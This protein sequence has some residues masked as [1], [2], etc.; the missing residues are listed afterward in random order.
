MSNL[1]TKKP[2]FEYQHLLV[3]DTLALL[4]ADKSNRLQVWRNNEQLGECYIPGATYAE[5][6]RISQQKENS[7]FHSAKAFLEFVGNGSSY[8]IQPKE[9]NRQIPLDNE[10]DRQIIA[11]A[12][13]LARENPHSVIILVTYDRTMKGLS[14]QSGLSNF[15]TLTAKELSDWFFLDYYR[16][17]VPQAVADA[18]QRIKRS[19]PAV[20][21]NNKPANPLPKQQ[22]QP[23]KRKNKQPSQIQPNPEL[24]K[25]RGSSKSQSQHPQNTSNPRKKQFLNPVNIV[26]ASA[27]AA[28]IVLAAITN[29]TT[30][31]SAA[32]V[33]QEVIDSKPVKPTPANL[34]T[35]AESSIIQFQN[36]KEPSILRQSLNEL[37]T[38]KNQQALR[39][40]KE[41]EQ[42]LSR[43]KHKYAIEVLASSGQKA[44]AVKMLEEIPQSYSEY[45]NV[46]KSLVK[47]QRMSGK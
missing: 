28:V 21:Q 22:N 2:V 19:Q 30:N 12:H 44:E 4:S 10:K 33:A 3:F 24:P 7:D 29:F 11:C 27:C 45:K 31:N 42:R 16:G 5:L 47:L 18:Y 26:L 15:C 14:A 41:G 25:L 17:K 37:Q 36:T 40:D 35:K 43:L 9:D 34:I 39:L 1:P 8:K 32:L 20:S 6:S 38:I 23:N 46:K 13:R